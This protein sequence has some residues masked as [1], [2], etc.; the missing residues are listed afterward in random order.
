MLV[1]TIIAAAARQTTALP[2][3][4]YKEF[5]ACPPLFSSRVSSTMRDIGGFTVSDVPGY[6]ALPEDPKVVAGSSAKSGG[7]PSKVTRNSYAA[8]STTEADDLSFLGET[9]SAVKSAMEVI[10]E[11]LNVDA[12]TTRGDMIE[13]LHYYEGGEEGDAVMDYHTDAGYMIAMTSGSF[14][15]GYELRVG[16]AGEE[17]GVFTENE[18]VVMAGQQSTDNEW[19]PL[20]HSVTG[21]GNDRSW[22]G[23]MY[24]AAGTVDLDAVQE[25]SRNGDVITNGIL[26]DGGD[27]D[28]NSIMCW[29]ACQDVSDLPCDAVDALCIDSSGGVVPFPD[30]KGMVMGYT[31]K[32]ASMVNGKLNATS[33]SSSADFCSGD[34][35]DMFMDGYQFALTGNSQCLNF[36]VPSF[37]LN[38]GMKFSLALV[39]S[40]ALGVGVEALATFRRSVFRTSRLKG[41]NSRKLL[42][43]L[44]GSQALLGYL[45]M[46]L[47][48]SYSVEVLGSVVVGLMTG[49]WFFNGADAFSEKSDPCCA[50]DFDYE[51]I[52]A[53]DDEERDSALFRRKN[54]SNSKPLME[55]A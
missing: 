1:S 47:A 33:P 4:S 16:E 8:S 44:H 22:Y 42:T 52:A 21:D 40:F 34:G 35:T 17:H 20:R 2:S 6:D 50:D 38:S 23:V 37:T 43:V 5:E 53:D 26:H 12:V 15:D 11:C 27:C 24:F 28:E 39:L 14:D 25:E 18:L 19:K 36:L 29:Q 55:S 7:D 32:C 41:T 54:A 31:L 49:H 10:G 13:H 30:S 51:S 46:C 9:R 45:L 48:M 3:Y